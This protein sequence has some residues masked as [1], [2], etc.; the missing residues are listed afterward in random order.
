MGHPCLGKLQLRGQG[1]AAALDPPLLLVSFAIIA[2][3]GSCWSLISPVRAAL[4]ADI[5]FGPQLLSVR[6]KL[7]ADTLLTLLLL[8]L[9]QAAAAR[10]V[11]MAL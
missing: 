4:P 9:L 2:A 10:L 8:L 5:N 11:L 7:K 6:K 1:G 3:W